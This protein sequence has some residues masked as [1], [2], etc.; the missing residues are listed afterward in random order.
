MK[1]L[2]LR[3]RLPVI[4][5]LALS[6]LLLFHTPLYSLFHSYDWRSN[7]NTH[8]WMGTE[9]VVD[10]VKTAEGCFLLLASTPRDGGLR[11]IAS[12]FL[13][14]DEDTYRQVA[15]GDRV[16]CAYDIGYHNHMGYLHS[17]TIV[18]EEQP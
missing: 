2:P 10:K 9:L 15:V 8:L 4:V 17:L 1:R 16:N 12:V 13:L 18:E 14:C 6:L 5:V 7:E 3:R 11:S